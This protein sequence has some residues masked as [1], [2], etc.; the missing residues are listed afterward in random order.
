VSWR[1][2]L[3]GLLAFVLAL[4]TV[5]P[6]RWAG[7]ML[8]S[9]M[10]CAQW[11]G[12][13]WRGRC[14]Q[15]TV[16]APGQGSITVETASWTLHPL[17][18]LHGRIVAELAL[19]DARGDV[20]GHMEL[21]RG[22]LLTLRGVSARV[23][24][25]PKLPSVMPDGWRGR[26]EINQLEL[27]WQVDRLRHLQG[28]FRF[29]DLRDAQGRE[30][31]DYRLSFPPSTS[32]PYTGQLNDEGGPLQLRGTLQLTADRKWSLD[33]TVALRGSADPA[34]QRTLEALGP[35]DASGRYPL[36]ATGSFTGPTLR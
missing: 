29:F 17:P 7:A 2:L 14:R 4:L 9:S 33:G 30:L 11:G 28:D 15:L 24:F 20:S 19:T 23:L 27:D 25:D 22:G 32:P 21:A 6:A 10:G 16:T 18:L 8:P 1:T 5:L 35:A 36:S 12:T 26:I 34:I 31:G 3:L 13:L